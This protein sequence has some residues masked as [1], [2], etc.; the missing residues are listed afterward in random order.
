[1]DE[2]PLLEGTGTEQTGETIE[3]YGERIVAMVRKD[4]L[5]RLPDDVIGR[6][7]ES[8]LVFGKA[9]AIKSVS[10]AMEEMSANIEDARHAANEIAR[11][12]ASADKMADALE[13]MT[14]TCDQYA[15]FIRE[16]VGHND[17]TM[18]PYLPGLEGEIVEARQA[19]ATHRSQ[20]DGR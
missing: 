7:K 14:E 8:H 2:I 12:A 11:K 16:S 10:N 17:I 6:I 1:M 20:T 18:H 19:L 15:S 13:N 4:M 3:E 9:C 5:D